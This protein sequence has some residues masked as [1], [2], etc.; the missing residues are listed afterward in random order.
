MSLSIFLLQGLEEGSSRTR[1]SPV[2]CRLELIQLRMHIGPWL[3]A[4]D[5]DDSVH[6]LLESCHELPSSMQLHFSRPKAGLDAGTSL[7]IPQLELPLGMLCRSGS[8]YHPNKRTGLIPALSE[9]APLDPSQIQMIGWFMA[10]NSNQPCHYDS[11]G[12]SM[13]AGR[14]EIKSIY[15]IVKSPICYGRR[16]HHGPFTYHHA[17]H[18][19][20]DITVPELLLGFIFVIAINLYVGRR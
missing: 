7:E 1:P 16:V 20:S 5:C 10:F 3:I 9:L 12:R 13:I 14:A 19:K 17:S 6:D 11:A 8:D 18:S 15:P 4:A 2:D